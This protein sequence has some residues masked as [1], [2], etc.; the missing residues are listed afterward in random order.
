MFS[1]TVDA[2]EIDLINKVARII[3][4]SAWDD[5]PHYAKQPDGTYAEDD[6]MTNLARRINDTNR[7]RAR[8]LASAVIAA[9]RDHKKHREA[10]AAPCLAAKSRTGLE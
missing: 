3:D 5:Q 6:G 9:V 7:A 4:S 10:G 2:R 8:E 1:S